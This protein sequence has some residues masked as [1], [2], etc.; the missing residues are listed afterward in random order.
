MQPEG[1]RSISFLRQ[2]LWGLVLLAGANAVL[3]GSLAIVVP[4]DKLCAKITHAF[5]EG[6][7]LTRDWPWHDEVRGIDPYSD[8]ALLQMSVFQANPA[9]KNAISSSLLGDVIPGEKP[10]SMCQVLR[11]VCEHPGALDQH[12]RHYHRYWF[13]PRAVNAWLLGLLDIAPLRVLYKT[14]NYLCFA[15]LALLALRISLRLFVV[16]LPISLAGIFASGISLF[17]PTLSHAPANLW[18]FLGPAVLLGIG[19]RLSG[20]ALRGATLLV[21][22]I[23]AYLD[24][25]N[26][27]PMN[28]A[29]LVAFVYQLERERTGEGWTALRSTALA[30]GAW[31]VGVVGTVLLKQLIAAAA[32]GPAEVF[33]SFI[34][35]LRF[36][37]GASDQSALGVEPSLAAPFLKLLH[38]TP[39]LV[40]GSRPLANLALILGA[41]GWVSATATAAWERVRG[42][43]PR[44]LADLAAM[45][46]ACGVL[47]AWY[48]IFGSHTQIHSWFMVRPVFVPIALGW[49]VVAAAL[50]DHLAGLRGDTAKAPIRGFE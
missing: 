23:A 35:Q 26:A 43:A 47:L 37:L 10:V 34:G 31:A 44:H 41:V 39:W 46:L 19:P 50:Y 15:L 1:R 38:E 49:T 45:V 2:A 14:S 32:F 40:H 7:L 29:L 22:C 30:L 8:C 5:A 4:R 16:A 42:R 33:S 25:M 6:T 28:G 36:R 24:M 13:G 27:L 9:W 48:V 17:G 20:A 21:G 11:E 18:A 12:Y 3:I